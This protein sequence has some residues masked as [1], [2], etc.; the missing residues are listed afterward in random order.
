MFSIRKIDNKTLIIIHD[1]FMSVLAWQFAWWSRFN[2]VF[3][4][5]FWENSLLT[6]PLVLIVQSII[7][8][9]FRL[10]LGVWRF[11]SI[12]DLWN[13]FRAS[14][15]GALSITLICF[16]VFR[17]EGIPR[18]ILIL[19]PF[20]L[21]FFLGAPRLGYRVW[22]DHSFNLKRMTGGQKVMIVGAGRAGEMLIREMNRDGSYIPVGFFDDNE[23]LKNSEI[24]GVKVLGKIEDIYDVAMKSEVD[25]IIIAI[26]SATNSEMQQ[27][28]SFC[29]QTNLPI[30]TLPA[31]QDMVSMTNALSDIREV[32]IED[33]L[34]RD[35]VELDWKELQKDILN[36]IILVTGGGGSIGKEL[37]LQIASLNPSKLIIFERSEF[38][39]YKVEQSLSDYSINLH[40]VLGDLCD[41]LKVENV[42]NEYRPDVIFHAAAYKHV[43]ILER[44]VREAV[45]NN[46]MGTKNIAD[47]A[48]KYACGKFVLISTDK[49]VN[50]TN[51]LGVTKRIAENYIENLNETSKTG[52][53]TVRFGNVLGSDGSVV[54]LFKEQ[55]NKG[56][57][58][59][60]TH[61][62][63]TRYFMTIKEACQLILQAGSI[64]K[65]GEI[66]VL[67]MGESVKISYLAEQMIS[68]SGLTPG[69]DIKIEYTGLRPGEKMHEELFYDSEMP[70]KTS[71]EKILLAKQQK[72]TP[73][74]I[75][76]IDKIIE[77]VNI[78][79][80]EKIKAQL[81]KLV[82]VQEKRENILMFN[83]L[84]T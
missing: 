24:H 70:E 13:I 60:V 8:R 9:R 48:D 63:V 82:P 58:I 77:T 75:S 14:L 64:G 40:P 80:N 44:E 81:N 67:D 11:A 29:E 46:I 72:L 52:F 20:F 36:K 76:K 2:F 7:F 61:P 30:R 51:I 4:F 15:F 18:S 54:P 6:I 31:L 73:D 84:K 42:I 22:K 66:F 43:P 83:K 47:M 32:S 41:K 62:E 23:R 26:P 21:M 17:L 45:R 1:L 37:C 59:T 27:I 3:P 79:D 39:L 33:L 57:P 55:I 65:G 25:L 50:P 5:E 71:H 69:K 19:Y 10:Y 35:K 38:N 49:A 34:G 28:I 12:P 16:M 78:F 56:G 74:F 68:L 53:F